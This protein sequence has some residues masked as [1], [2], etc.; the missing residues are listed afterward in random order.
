MN[1]R[2]QAIY[3]RLVQNLPGTRTAG[4]TKAMVV[5]QNFGVAMKDFAALRHPRRPVEPHGML[6]NM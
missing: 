6:A 1:L 5:M 2:Y 4:R 3:D